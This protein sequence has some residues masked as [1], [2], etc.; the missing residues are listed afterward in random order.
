MT[1]SE[2]RMKDRISAGNIKIWYS[3]IY[4]AEILTVCYYLCDQRCKHC[5]IFSGE[6]CKELK[7]MTWKQMTE[8]VANC[9]DFCK[10]YGRVPYFYIT[11]GDPI[12]HPDFWKLMVL[13]KSKKIPFTLMGNPFHLNDEICRMLKVCGCEKYQMSLDG[14]RETHDWFRKP[15]EG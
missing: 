1:G 8:V 7:S 11:G 3:A 4:F 13:M 14:M 6:G 5:Y 12:L 15:D 2:S 10:V 9:E